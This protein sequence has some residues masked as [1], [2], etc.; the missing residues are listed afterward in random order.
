[1]RPLRSLILRSTAPSYAEKESAEKRGPCLLLKQGIGEV[2]ASFGKRQ[3]AQNGATDA[4]K[5]Y[6]ERSARRGR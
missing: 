2:V 1:M 4:R 5:G 6:R 3:N